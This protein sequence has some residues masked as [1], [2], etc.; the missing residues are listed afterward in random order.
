MSLFLCSS[1]KWVSC[2]IQPQKYEC[3]LKRQGTS[4]EVFTRNFCSPS[5]SKRPYKRRDSYRLF[6]LY[7]CILLS[8][9]ARALLH[10]RLYCTETL[11]LSSLQPNNQI[12]TCR[13]KWPYCM[14]KYCCMTSFKAPCR[15]RYSSIHV[16]VVGSNTKLVQKQ[17][18]T[19]PP[20]R[21]VSPSRRGRRTISI[22]CLSVI[23]YEIGSI[24]CTHIDETDDGYHGTCMV[25]YSSWAA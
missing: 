22:F 9:F 1:I 16:F 6:R 23:G 24:R 8:Q 21:Q 13:C 11:S 2:Q 15:L 7:E 18:H 3:Y 14:Q 20:S 17:T 12:R 4:K 25:F 19:V 5:V 10:M